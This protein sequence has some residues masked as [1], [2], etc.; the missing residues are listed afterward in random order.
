MK[1]FIDKDSKAGAVASDRGMTSSEELRGSAVHSAEDCHG[2][3][4]HEMCSV[5]EKPP[6]RRTP[7]DLNR[8]LPYFQELEA[9]KKL[10]AMKEELPEEFYLKLLQNCWI[11]RMKKSNFVCKQGDK[12]D[13]FYIILQGHVQFLSDNIDKTQ[14]L[15]DH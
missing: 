11:E 10:V 15:Q 6:S 5:L 14:K 9:F 4:V 12:G 3:K 13:K 7:A 1:L 2:I 8:I